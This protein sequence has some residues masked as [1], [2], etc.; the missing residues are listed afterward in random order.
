MSGTKNKAI[1]YLLRTIAITAL[2]Y[3]TWIIF[4]VVD[5]WFG[6][7]GAIISVV[8]FPITNVFMPFIMLFVPSSAA[9]PA[10]LWPAIIL[11]G[12]L[13]WIAKKF[14]GTVMLPNI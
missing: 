10:A 3:N 5:A 7:V 6:L 8:L 4:R 11:I 13:D 14:D 2:L 12:I 1:I 9:A